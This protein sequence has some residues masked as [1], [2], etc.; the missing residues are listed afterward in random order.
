VAFQAENAADWG[1][2]CAPQRQYWISPT[3]D[4]ASSN[5]ILRDLN[6]VVAWIETGSRMPSFRPPLVAPADFRFGPPS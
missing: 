5:C 3:A 1:K 4:L 6:Q 2:W